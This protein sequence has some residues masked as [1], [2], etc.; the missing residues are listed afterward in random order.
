MLAQ[1]REVLSSVPAD[2]YAGRLKIR[3]KASGIRC[4]VPRPRPVNVQEKSRVPFFRVRVRA[5]ARVGPLVPSPVSDEVWAGRFVED[6]P[7]SRRGPRRASLTANRQLRSLNS[8]SFGC[9]CGRG[10][11]WGWVVGET[12]P[13]EIWAATGMAL[14]AYSAVDVMNRARYVVAF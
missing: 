13:K 3:C 12:E 10:W 5:R 6:F 8:L 7:S 4:E 9:G 14:Y 11:G 2:I 1:S